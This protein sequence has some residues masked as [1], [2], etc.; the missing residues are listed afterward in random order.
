MRNKTIKSLLLPALCFIAA[1]GQAQGTLEDYRRA[2]SLYEKFNATQVYND[3]ADIRWDGK[4]AFHYSVYTP[5]GTDY[6][7]GITKET[8]LTYEYEEKRR[9]LCQ[10]RIQNTR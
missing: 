8:N 6:N 1:N 5:E 4:T 3:P 2:Y 9:L 7:V 10:I